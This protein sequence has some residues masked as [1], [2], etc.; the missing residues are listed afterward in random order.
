MGDWGRVVAVVMAGCLTCAEGA[1]AQVARRVQLRTLSP[2]DILYV[3]LGGGGNT[4]AL[5]RED[6]TVLIDTK[7]AGWGKAIQ[8]A[9]EAATDR[10]VTTIV[11]SH[12]HPDHAGS[13]GEFGS[14]VRVIAHPSAATL[15]LRATT[16]VTDKLTLFDGRDQLDIH[17]FGRGHT[18]GDLVVVFPQK[19]L[20]YLGDLFP[21]KSAPVIDAAAGGSGTA[22]PDTLRRVVTEIKGVARVVTGHP[23]GVVAKRDARA[24]SVDISTPATMTW[25]DLEEYA[26]FTRDFLAAVRE[27]KAAGRTATQ[28]AASLT[29]PARYAAYDMTRAADAVAAIYR[30]L[31]R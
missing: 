9:I 24:S 28:A 20:A 18:G 15:G 4:L 31:D 13:N 16:P 7:E 8:E 29:L 3:L 23:E 6:G 2:G 5:L 14:D 25:A 10:P 22:L 17:Y 19:R 30:E 12:G 11:N 21:S 1:D 26:D 27:A